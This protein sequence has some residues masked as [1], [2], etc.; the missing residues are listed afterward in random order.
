MGTAL[1]Q[2]G[3]EP[4]DVGP[5]L[6]EGP[7]IPRPGGVVAGHAAR[8]SLG[9]DP[10]HERLPRPAPE[11]RRRILQPVTDPFDLHVND[12]KEVWKFVNYITSEVPPPNKE[13]D[14]LAKEVEDLKKQVR[15]IQM[16]LNFR[17]Q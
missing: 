3:F 16:T 9:L 17:D 13:K 11:P 15:A 14:D 1:K 12:L 6:C 2:F 10:P 4:G 7:V 5:N 8:P